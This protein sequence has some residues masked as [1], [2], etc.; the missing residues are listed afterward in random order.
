MRDEKQ[1]MFCELMRLN[2][3]SNSAVIVTDK[4]LLSD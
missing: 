1:L 4:A 3:L 2:L